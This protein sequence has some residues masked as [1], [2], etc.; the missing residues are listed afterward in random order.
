MSRPGAETDSPRKKAIA[1]Q[2]KPIRE[3]ERERA[4]LLEAIMPREER[5][6]ISPSTPQA[7]LNHA[8]GG[9]I[10]RIIVDRAGLCSK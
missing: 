3:R 2:E 6:T 4:V 10:D 1:P 9:E 5:Y 8:E 7:T